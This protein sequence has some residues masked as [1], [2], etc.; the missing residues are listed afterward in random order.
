MFLTTSDSSENKVLY[1]RIFSKLESTFS[2]HVVREHNRS[3]DA[4]RLIALL[5]NNEITQGCYSLFHVVLSSSFEK[6]EIWAAARIAGHG[7]Y[8]WDHFLGSTIRTMC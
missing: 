8:K 2:N 1:V 5:G 3:I 4:M 7:A 6:E